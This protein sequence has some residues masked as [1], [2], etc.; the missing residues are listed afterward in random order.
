MIPKGKY[1]MTFAKLDGSG[2]KTETVDMTGNREPQVSPGWIKLGEK[3]GYADLGADVIYRSEP[4]KP[5]VLDP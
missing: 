1:R 2:K 5:K 4:K 3:G